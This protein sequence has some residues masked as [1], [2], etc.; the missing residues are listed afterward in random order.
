MGI[1]KYLDA[2]SET[3]LF[4]TG[5]LGL[6]AIDAPFEEDVDASTGFGLFAGIG[7]EFSS[8]WTIEADILYS[9][10]E[11]FGVDLDSFGVRVSVNVLAF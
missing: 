8:H 1:T 7:H 5:G 3:G 11:E 9:K 2:A 6:S 4:L 10:V